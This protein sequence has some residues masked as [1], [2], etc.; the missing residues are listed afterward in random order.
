[1]AAVIVRDAGDGAALAPRTGRASLDV[2]AARARTAGDRGRHSFA[3]AAL[4]KR[5]SSWGYRRTQGELVGL[6][7]KLAAS[8]VWTILKQEEIEPAPRRQELSWA[9]FLRTQAASILEC[10]FLK[11][12]RWVTQQA[13]N[14]LDFGDDG[15]DRP[16]ILIRDRDRKFTRE[17]DEVFRSEGVR[18]IKAPMRAPKARA[19]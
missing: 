4:G 11:D 6:G 18:V 19:C 2:C 12:G 1:M 16:W 7:I 9:E 13:R 10:D 3:R 8:T 17:F 5:E 15:A 14:L